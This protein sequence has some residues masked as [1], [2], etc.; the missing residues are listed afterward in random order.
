MDRAL[1]LALAAL[2]LTGCPPPQGGEGGGASTVEAIKQRG[3]LIVATDAGYVPF[4]VIE[5]DGSITGFDVDLATAVAE[6]LGVALELRNVA[7]NGIIGELRTG[8]CDAIFSGM[9]ITEDRQQAVA[10][11]EPYFW[12]GQVVVKRKGDARIT[13]WEDLDAEGMTVAVQESTTGEIAIRRT[14]PQATLLR[15]PK[16]D[17]ACL[18]VMQEK[19]DAVVFDHPYLMQYVKE[20]A[21]DRLEGIW[22]PFTTEPIGAAVRKDSLDLKAAIDATLAKLEASG[23]LAKLKARY[24]GE[25]AEVVAAPAEPAAA[26]A[27][28]GDDPQ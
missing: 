3:K 2:L 17:A 1:A 24:F 6:E 14:C 13:S 27:T 19:A 21:P 9:S 28:A 25:A 22:Q 10:F 11:S 8:K 16:T 4:E 15:F 5:Q 7:W 12:I 23:E 18:A 20:K 26:A